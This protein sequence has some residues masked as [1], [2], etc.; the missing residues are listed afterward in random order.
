MKKT[1]ILGF[2]AAAVLVAM[3]SCSKKDANQ[4]VVGETE[5]AVGEV[6][7]MPAEGSSDTN[8]IAT[9]EAVAV[10]AVDTTGSAA[11]N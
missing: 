2:A 3:S 10:E 6:L 9:G 4:E 7:E 1:V 11:Q 8:V 5:I